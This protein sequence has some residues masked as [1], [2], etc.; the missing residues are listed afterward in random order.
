MSR[1]KLNTGLFIS[2]LSVILIIVL[3]FINRK[4]KVVQEINIERN[5]PNIVLFL[6][7]DLGYNDL[8]CY[9][10][11][12]IQTPYL[13]RL[14]SK[15]MLFTSYYAPAPVCSPSRGALLTGR[16][17]NRLG[18]YDWIDYQTPVH[19][20]CKEETI[21]EMLGDAGYETCMVGK[22]HLNGYFNSPRHPQPD[23]HGFDYW[24]ATRN[25]ADYSHKNPINF[26]RNGKPVGPL[27]GFSCQIIVDE[28]I[29][30]LKSYRP[31]NKPFFQYIS[32]H[33][34]HEPIASPQSLINRYKI[35][36]LPK[37]MYY[38]NVT[39]MD[40]A[41]GRYMDFLDTT[42]LIENTLIFFSSDNGPE[43][44]NRYNKAWRSYGSAEPLKGMKLH[45]YEGGI[46]VPAIIRWDGIVEPG[47]IS[48][49]PV[50]GMDILPTVAEYLNL[51]HDG[52]NFDGRN[53]LPVLKGGK[54]NME[55]PIY[56]FYYA[57]LGGP[58]AALRQGDYKI[59]GYTNDYYYPEDRFAVHHLEIIKNAELVRYELYNVKQD[60]GERYDL[61]DSLPE[62]FQ[63]MK[64][65]IN[66]QFN[67]VQ[68]E[69]PDWR[70]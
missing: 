33:E 63:E 61:S 68:N 59:L 53:I 9:G 17:P 28:A 20:S 1:N 45:L 18:I 55:K 70:K 40:S 23:A 34:P 48:S 52:L 51:S 50:S 58:K 39:N 69:G 54:M 46:R 38:A 65:L 41:I 11:Q 57:A 47:Q 37:A 36:T 4:D 26:V 49:E 2:L 3:I 66:K 14:A 13:D 64:L 21:A 31:A 30:W 42:R 12:V 15:G 35:D 25:N 43:T 67:S 60:I 62:K 22:W 56:W 5:P 32:F 8:G 44:L 7:D 10:N 27:E 16:N 6:A 24:F 19:L 29:E